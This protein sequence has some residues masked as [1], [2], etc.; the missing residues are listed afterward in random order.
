[1]DQ[2]KAEKEKEFRENIGALK[3]GLLAGVD[4]SA[5]T[6]AKALRLAGYD[7][8]TK[9]QA[10]HSKRYCM[11]A[12]NDRMDMDFVE[13]GVDPIT[14]K[15]VEA[16]SVEDNHSRLSLCSDVTVEPTTEFVIESLEKIFEIYGKPR[17][18][19]TDHGTQWYSTSSGKCRFDEWCKEQGIEHTMS[20]I[21]TPECNGTVERY[22]GSLRREAN[23]P[24]EGTVQ[25]YEAH[26]E[27]Y[28][29]FYNTE[30]PHYSLGFR[31]PQEVYDKTSADFT[32][33]DDLI[34]TALAETA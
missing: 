33:A 1:M 24:R 11:Q 27:S 30:R 32:T 22:H 20:P 6:V 10:K 29:T 5:P 9:Y 26:L 7:P 12:P 21:R 17:K 19:H 14:G 3:I 34:R 25:E 13:V 15:K 31:T 8:V 16:L 2:V 4:A 23:L 28:R 18:I